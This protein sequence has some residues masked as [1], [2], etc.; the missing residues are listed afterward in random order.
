MSIHP[1]C[2]HCE[3]VFTLNS[4]SISRND[5]W[6]VNM[7]LYLLIKLLKLYLPT[8]ILCSALIDHIK[9][10]R[11][12]I[13]I[14][15]N[16]K[17]SWNG[18]LFCIVGFVVVGCVV[19]WACGV[20]YVSAYVFRSGLRAEGCNACCE[21][22]MHGCYEWVRVLLNSHILKGHD[23][24]SELYK[25]SSFCI[26]PCTLECR[27]CRRE[28]Q[29][30]LAVT[31]LLPALCPPPLPHLPSGIEF[32]H[33]LSLSTL[34]PLPP[35]TTLLSVWFC[36]LAAQRVYNVGLEPYTDHCQAVSL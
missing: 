13:Q 26:T 34:G 9:V 6:F 17:Q 36:C 1:G 7:L 8:Y 30:S 19:L 16:C 22:C 31:G 14:Y 4:W 12:L 32:I 15:I 27:F 33:G 21:G 23:S 5:W 29:P 20:L 28:F 25:D 18:N 3:M 24:L 10:E 2:T 11:Q 35:W